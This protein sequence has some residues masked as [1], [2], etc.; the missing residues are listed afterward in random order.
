MWLTRPNIVL[1]SEEELVMEIEKKRKTNNMV[2]V[3]PR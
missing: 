1:G 3:I 2:I